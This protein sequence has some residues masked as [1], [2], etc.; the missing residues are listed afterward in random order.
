VSARPP[1]N[2]ANAQIEPA[3]HTRLASRLPTITTFGYA[4]ILVGPTAIGFVVQISSPS[5][6][7][8]AMGLLPVGVAIR[9]RVLAVR[10]IHPARQGTLLKLPMMR[11]P[12]R[13]RSARRPAASELPATYP[14]RLSSAAVIG[15]ARITRRYA[16]AETSPTIALTS[17]AGTKLPVACTMKPVTVG[18]KAPPR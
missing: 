17:S 16:R 14:A 3:T 4:G 1:L 13:G 11:P 15:A 7:I 12:L 8:L 6:A 5:I 10:T 18:A 9:W 2:T